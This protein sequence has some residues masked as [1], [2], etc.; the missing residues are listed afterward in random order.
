M[1][2]KNSNLILQFAEGIRNDWKIITTIFT[3]VAGGIGIGAR[4]AGKITDNQTTVATLKKDQ[5]LDE[6][7]ADDQQAEI[8]ALTIEVTKLQEDERLREA[9]VCK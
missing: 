7:S 1:S 9:G 5:K 4:L 3:I 6:Q 8:D 2:T